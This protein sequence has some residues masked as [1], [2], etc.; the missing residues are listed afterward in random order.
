[1]SAV[2]ALRE[3]ASRNEAVVIGDDQAVLQR[4]LDPN[5]HLAIWQRREALDLEGLDW[6]EIADIDQDVPVAGLAS[7]IPDALTLAGY[8]DATALAGAIVSLASGFAAL[9]ACDALR[10]RLDVIETDACRK[11]HADQVTVRLIM[12]LVGPG[13]QW[14]H[15]N[16][17]PQIPEGA[18]QIGDVGL[19]KGR[20][21]AEEPVILHRSPPIAATGL[22][23]LLLVIDP[24]SGLST[25]S[26]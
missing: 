4:I 17:E 24:G 12:P 11:F 16:I 8:R 19:F 21:W 2:R 1:M 5:V 26:R 15:A 9:M 23:R 18:L 10:I 6:D 20:V 25:P 13:T 7:A 22:T 14:T 3:D